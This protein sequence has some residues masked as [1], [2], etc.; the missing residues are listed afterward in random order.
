VLAVAGLV[1]LVL[2]AGAVNGL[3]GFGFAVI[4]TMGLAA[5]VDPATAVAFMIL[6]MVAVNLALVGELSPAQLRSCGRRFWPL[7]LAALLGTVAGMV[8]LDAVPARPLRVALGIV[9]LGFV[10]SVQRVVSFPGLAR[11]KEGCFV[12]TPRGMAG[13]GGVSGLL[14]GGTNVGVQLVAFLRSCDLSHG[15]FV[16]VVGLVF[17]GINAVRVGVA[18]AFGLYPDLAVV[19]GS[20]AAAIPAVAGVA[21]GRRLR[22]R[23]SERARR[24][25]VLG[26]LL[27]IGV[28]LSL[29]AVGV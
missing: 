17:V 12:E 6:P 2:V 13:I 1:A 9:T 8:L 15:L 18:G 4:A 14:F 7:I 25:A 22:R 11:A 10:A 5:V 26:V 24:A 27:A 28:R 21:V 20:A 23:V 3:A 29:A 16:G 19:A